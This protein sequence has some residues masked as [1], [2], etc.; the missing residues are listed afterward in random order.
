MCTNQFIAAQGVVL[1][2]AQSL[3]SIANALPQEWH[4]QARA[5]VGDETWSALVKDSYLRSHAN[6]LPLDTHQ[7]QLHYANWDFRGQETASPVRLSLSHNH[8]YA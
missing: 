1:Q 8:D 4:A 5:D 3:Y 2:G 6:A 7:E